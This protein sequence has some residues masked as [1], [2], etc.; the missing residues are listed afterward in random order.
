M[1]SSEQRP[2][3]RL[4]PQRKKERILDALIDRLEGLARRRPVLIIFEDAH[5]I[6]PTSRELL[7]LTV[8]RVR[9]LPVLLIITFRPEF[10]P[11]WTGEPHVTTLV[12]NRLDQCNR[13]ALVRQ[14]VGGKAIPDD[15]V[16]Q[17]VERTDG[18][19][20]FIEELTKSRN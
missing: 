6:D 2:L 18:V 10:Q 20:L 11:P 8:E 1:P 16:V 15:V 3:P 13:P 19:P 5:W 12:L 17:I 4:S 7:D 9:N 14:I